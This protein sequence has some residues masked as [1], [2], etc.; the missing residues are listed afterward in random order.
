MVPHSKQCRFQVSRSSLEPRCASSASSAPPQSRTG[1]EC[2]ECL[3]SRSSRA[4]ARGLARAIRC[5]G[6][7]RTV[8]WILSAQ[9]PSILDALS[10][11]VLYST[12]VW[13]SSFE[14]RVPRS[15]SSSSWSF[16][17]ELSVELRVSSFELRASSSS[18]EFRVRVWLRASR[19]EFEFEF[20]VRVSSF[21]FEFGLRVSSS[22]FEF[23][24]R[25]RVSS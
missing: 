16:E 7:Q 6:K 24:V 8:S 15:S 23:E 5:L 17:F 14:F 12:S 22:S 1:D 3:K 10:T 4:V 18:F 21:E 2:L 20:R 11:Q 13:T 25:V 19:F 9:A